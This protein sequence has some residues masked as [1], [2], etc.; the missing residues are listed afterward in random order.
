MVVEII[1]KVWFY[2]EARV[3]V[4]K[5]VTYDFTSFCSEDWLATYGSHFHKAKLK[6]LS[7]GLTNP[8]SHFLGSAWPHSSHI[9]K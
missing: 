8:M 7:D 2:L 6:Y 4:Q 9:S 5:L 3:T 1:V